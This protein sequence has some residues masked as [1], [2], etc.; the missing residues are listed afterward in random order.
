M[1]IRRLNHSVY[2][3]LYHFVWG[4]KYRRKILKPYVRTELIKS[5]KNVQERFPDWYIQKINTA[6]DHIHLLCE[7]PPKYPLTKAVQII[8]SESAAHLK[9]RF[10]FI[11]KMEDS[12]WGT[13]FFVSTI[14]INE[15]IIKKYIQLQDKDDR[16]TDIQDEFS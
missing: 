3:V 5:L 10:P 11:K 16:G 6:Q 15:D 7:I 1:R 8:K 2:Q 9:K 14:G 12:V 4:T 13:G